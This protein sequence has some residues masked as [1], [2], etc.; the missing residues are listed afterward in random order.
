MLTHG[1]FTV[2]LASQTVKRR[3]VNV[4]WLLGRSHTYNNSNRV[5]WHD[6]NSYYPILTLKALGT[7]RV[8]LSVLLAAT[9]LV[10]GMKWVFRHQD[11]QMFGLKLNKYE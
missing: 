2:E 4:S 11:L 5:F 10:L 6:L 1:R 3:W 9:S 8:V 7:T